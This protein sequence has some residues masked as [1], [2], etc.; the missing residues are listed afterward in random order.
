MGAILQR[1]GH[2]SG[3]VQADHIRDGR[4]L[5]IKLMGVDGQKLLDDEMHT[6]DFLFINH[7]GSPCSTGP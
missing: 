5:A 6:R 3:T 4:G 7:D 2:G 1:L